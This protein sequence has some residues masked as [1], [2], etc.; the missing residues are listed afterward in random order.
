[1]KKIILAISVVFAAA[2]TVNAQTDKTGADYENLRGPFITN[3]FWDNWSV[4][5]G[6][7][8]NAW[9]RPSTMNGEE[10]KGFN[11]ITPMFQ[12]GATK[13]LAPNYGIRLQGN[14]GKIKDY[15]SFAGVY[16]KEQKSADKYLLDFNYWTVEADFLFNLSN[17]IG[18]YKAARFYNATLFAGFGFG[19]SSGADLAGDRYTDNEFLFNAGLLNTFRITEA[20]DFYA[21][22][23]A[24]VVSQ[25]FAAKN[26]TSE[27]G[28]TYL[29][30]TK[31]GLIPSLTVG[32]TYKFKDRRF[33]K[34]EICNTAPYESRISDLKR[35]LAMAQAI[36]DKYKAVAE[37]EPEV[38]EVI[39]EVSETVATPLTIFFRI[40]KADLSEFEMLHVRYAADI[41]RNDPDQE[42]VYILTGLADSGTGSAERNQTLSEKR[43]EAVRNALIE[44][45]VSADRLETQ[46]LGG[47][48]NPFEKPE[49]NRVVIID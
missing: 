25:E 45:G 48:V 28:Q 38:I 1:M 26:A 47:T 41:I 22:L 15:T 16:T 13:M 11:K 40:G 6:A 33:Y 9:V 32:F 37:A 19:R 39:E 21:E 43:A 36:A 7:G 30:S 18:G 5:M 46:A 23:K 10:Y 4:S 29:A 20:L 31:A 24:N 34:H 12:L 17:A 42:K 27:A 14:Y 44:L 3:P 8:V 35:E 2:V 49:M